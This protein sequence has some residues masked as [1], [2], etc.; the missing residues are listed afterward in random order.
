MGISKAL[1]Q[2]YASLIVRTGANVQK[3]QVV[4][5]TISVELI[6]RQQAKQTVTVENVDAKGPELLGSET[7]SSTW[8]G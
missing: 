8:P 4:M 1:L 7:G 5:L 6:N 3:G 2:K